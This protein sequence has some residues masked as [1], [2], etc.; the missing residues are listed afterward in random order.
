MSNEEI[1][2]SLYL[3]ADAAN[4]WFVFGDERIPGHKFIL[5][6]RSPWLDT[7]FNGALPEGEEVNMN[8]AGVS[9]EA[10]KEF[11][12]FIY[13]KKTQLT[14]D[15]IVE[16]IYLA[17]LSLF[18]EF[19]DACEEFL[20]NSVTTENIFSVY[21]LAKLY[22]TKKLKE[23]CEE[24]IGKSAEKVIKSPSFV[25][26]EYDNLLEFLQYDG[27]LCEEKDIFDACI[28][29][30]R[31]ACTRN[32]QDPL[33]PAN[34]RAHLKDSIYEI[35]FISMTAF[36]VGACINSCRGLFSAEELEEILLMIGGTRTDI[37]KF[38]SIQRTI[39]NPWNKDSKGHCF[40]RF[41][42]LWDCYIERFQL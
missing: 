20:M 16:A 14:M 19:F 38:N 10:F 37:N 32:N 29:W 36:E 5:S 35:R 34:L 8:N 31:A 33:D 12:R 9:T 22:E 40:S 28:A 17:K 3:N 21:Q 2:G 24:I 23:I 7:M 25:Q 11:L 15:N 42:I 41:D 4:V 18:D 13:Q 30:A 39:D 26:L 1:I 27:L 6:K